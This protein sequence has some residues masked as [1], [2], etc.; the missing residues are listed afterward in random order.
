MCVA[1]RCFFFRAQAA[2][3]KQARNDRANEGK[4]VKAL[5]KLTEVGSQ[6]ALLKFVL[7]CFCVL[8]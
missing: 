5:V 8:L 4:L 1:S 3:V 6:Q 7:P 2:V